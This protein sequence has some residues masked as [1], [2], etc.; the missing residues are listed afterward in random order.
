[1]QSGV[2]SSENMADIFRGI[3]QRRRHG[4]LEIKYHDCAVEISFVNGKIVDITSAGI[5]AQLEIVQIFT[6]AGLLKDDADGCPNTYAALFDWLQ[7]R[8]DKDVL[9]DPGLYRRVIKHKVLDKIYALNLGESAYYTFKVEM[10][11]CE[12]DFLPSIS[13]GQFLLDLVALESEKARFESIFPAGCYLRAG[14]LADIALSEE[15]QSIYKEAKAGCSL[16][17]L[18]PRCMVSAFTLQEALLSLHDRGVIFVSNEAPKQARAESPKYDDLLSALND[19][20]ESIEAMAA[21]ALVEEIGEQANGVAVDSTEP[22]KVPLA[23]AKPVARGQGA[24]RR[25]VATEIVE[26]IVV[27]EERSVRLRI[28]NTKMLHSATV[29]RIC[30]F[31]LLSFG[32]LAPWLFWQDALMAFQVF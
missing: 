4:S 1:M 27:D 31:V 23:K 28:L 8:A 26:E 16:V 25:H 5:S 6:A 2:I 14:E 24:V 30:V 17:E 20:T 32:V 21:Q 11:D 29:P 19:A 9:I 18:K 15:E 3:S 22:E 10:V 13:V 12:K 7:G